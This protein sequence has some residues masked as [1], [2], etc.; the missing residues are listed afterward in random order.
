MNRKVRISLE[1]A[2]LS[3]IISLLWVLGTIPIII[4]N[5]SEKQNVSPL[6]L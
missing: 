3:T 6:D 2:I 1:V 5:L 4:F